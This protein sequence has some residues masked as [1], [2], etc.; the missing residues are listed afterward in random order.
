MRGGL[1]AA[2]VI[3]GFALAGMP[4]PAA[5][6]A[7]TIRAFDFGFD[8]DVVNVV[9]GDTV[10][11]TIATNSASFH[12]FKFDDGPEYPPTGPAGQGPAWTNQS[13][14]FTAAGR[15]TYVCGAH[16]FMLGEIDVSSAGSTP[17]PSPS[18]TAT[19]TPTPTPQGGSTDPGDPELEVRTL[20]LTADTFCTRRGPRCTRPG[21]KL[22]IDLSEAAPVSGTLKRRP[23]RGRARARGFG[24]VSFGSVAAGPRTLSFTRNAGGRRLTA[25]RYTLSVAVAGRAPRSL[26]FRVR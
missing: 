13:R 9:A 10:T 12:S 1:V 5:R 26:A 24:R 21:V 8:P 17:T 19:P 23:P 2:A 7:E 25:G 14:T 4:A 22:R 6:Q 20:R 15:Y 16:P 18:A 3:V 11:F